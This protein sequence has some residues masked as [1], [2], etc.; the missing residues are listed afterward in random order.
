MQGVVVDMQKDD[1]SAC[2]PNNVFGLKGRLSPPV[3]CYLDEKE[4]LGGWG[5]SEDISNIPEDLGIGKLDQR[6]EKFD[7]DD[8]CDCECSL[9]AGSSAV[10]VAHFFSSQWNHISSNFRMIFFKL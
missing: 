2:L 4:D 6:R 1:M 5:K 7:P 10:L 9:S 3:G 8:D